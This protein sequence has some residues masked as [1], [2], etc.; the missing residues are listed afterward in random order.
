[1]T[2]DGRREV[3]NMITKTRNDLLRERREMVA[4]EQHCHYCGFYFHI[5]PDSRLATVDHKIPLSRGGSEDIGNKVVCCMPCNV[6][7]GR[8][9]YHEY[10]RTR[11]CI[12]LGNLQL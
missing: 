11:A 5:G 3:G 4:S 8:L 2:N 1:M 9:T 7:K 6:E 12:A 10:I